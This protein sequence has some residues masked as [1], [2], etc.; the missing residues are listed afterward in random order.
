MVIEELHAMPMMWQSKNEFK[1][2]FNEIGSKRIPV[3]IHT[4]SH[5]KNKTDCH[6]HH[7][8]AVRNIRRL[9]FNRNVVKLL[10]FVLESRILTQ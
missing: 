5:P 9:T 6:L 4:N 10:D 1:L 2:L 8:H 7:Q 3:N